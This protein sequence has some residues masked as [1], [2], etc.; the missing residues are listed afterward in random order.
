LQLQAVVLEGI[1]V[2]EAM[3][4]QGIQD[5]PEVIEVLGLQTHCIF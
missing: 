3:E 4:E 5:V 1:P 2:L